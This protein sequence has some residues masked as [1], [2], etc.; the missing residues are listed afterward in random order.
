MSR[1]QSRKPKP[2]DRMRLNPPEM[3]VTAKDPKHAHYARLLTKTL[4]HDL[5]TACKEHSTMSAL[6]AIQVAR[7]YGA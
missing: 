2:Q 5:E 1:K 6:F 7:Y 4:N 3:L